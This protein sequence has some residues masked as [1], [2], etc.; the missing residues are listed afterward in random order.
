MRRS[1]MPRCEGPGDDLRRNLSVPTST[2]VLTNKQR[3]S[4]SID[5]LLVVGRPSQTRQHQH[6]CIRSSSVQAVPGC[7]MQTAG[8]LRD[9][10]N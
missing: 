5:P 6:F 2:T 8:T 1:R 9:T 3:G 10:I 7:P 4:L